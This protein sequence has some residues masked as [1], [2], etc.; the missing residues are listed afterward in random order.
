MDFVRIGT[1]FAL[2]TLIATILLVPIFFP[3]H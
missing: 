1:P 3:F 2:I